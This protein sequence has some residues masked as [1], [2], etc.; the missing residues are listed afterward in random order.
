MGMAAPAGH[1]TDLPPRIPGRGGRARSRRGRAGEGAAASA[2][3]GA[4]LRSWPAARR[5]PRPRWPPRARHAGR[6]DDPRRA[7]PDGCGAGRAER[8]VARSM[9]A[10][11]G[12]RRRPARRGGY[13]GHGRDVGRPP[14]SASGAA[15]RRSGATSFAIIVDALVASALIPPVER[16]GLRCHAHRHELEDEPDLDRGRRAGSGPLAARG[17]PRRTELFVLPPSPRSGS[18]ASARG[19]ASLGRPDVHP[20]EPLRTPATC[21]RRCWPTSAVA[22]WSSAIPSAAATTEDAELI[23]PKVAA[24]LRAP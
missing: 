10:R 2:T 24:S 16:T 4:G 11:R 21:R 12:P 13:E 15:D 20:D 14:A 23:A 6:Q 5:R 8:A 3:T 17:G 1:R 7:R 9:P 22:S 18:P 19:H